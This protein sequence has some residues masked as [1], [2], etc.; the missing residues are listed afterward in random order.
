METSEKKLSTDGIRLKEFRKFMGIP[1]KKLADSLGCSQP[2]LSKIESG[3]L[4][5][6]SSLREKL[7]DAY[8][9]INPSWLFSG[10]GEMTLEVYDSNYVSKQLNDS[11]EPG[12]LDHLHGYFER[13]QTLIEQGKVPAAVIATI[14]SDLRKI[15]QFQQQI[16][17]SLQKSHDVLVESL[18]MNLKIFKKV[19]KE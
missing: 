2:N 6:S 11:K 13:F 3:E 19:F 17:K 4:G 5:I 12:D 10:N 9:E 7:L 14:F 16:L 15:H 18:E 8:P 1:Q